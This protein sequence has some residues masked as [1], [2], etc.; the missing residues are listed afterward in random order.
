MTL[1]KRPSGY[2]ANLMCN[3]LHDLIEERGTPTSHVGHEGVPHSS[4]K[5]KVAHYVLNNLLYKMR[6][7]RI[8]EITDNSTELSV[9]F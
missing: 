9:Y 7:Q 3:F 1:R 4:G 8:G 2:I 5:L 6:L